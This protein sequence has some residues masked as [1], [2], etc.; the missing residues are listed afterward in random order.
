MSG[1]TFDYWQN[2]IDYVIE[3]IVEAIQKSGKEVPERLWSYFIRKYEEERMCPTFTDK[4]LRR[5][6]EGIY[7]LKKAYIYAQRIDWLLACDDGEKEFEERL[8]EELDALEKES[9]IGENGVRYIPIDRD[10]D[11]FAEE[12]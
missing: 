11:P 1:G 6:E 9:M 10:V 5:F 12:E 7:V 8:R 2:Q 4:T 3:R